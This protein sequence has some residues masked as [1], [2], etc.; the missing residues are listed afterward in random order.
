MIPAGLSPRA[1]RRWIADHLA[2]L[3][4][5]EAEIDARLLVR[6]ASGIDPALPGSAAEA[7]LGGDETTRL[8]DL[9]ARRS[10]HEPM[11]RIAGLREFRGLDFL[12][13]EACLVP[14]PDTET[15]VDVAL[16]LL[17][18][19]RPARILDLGT[20][21]G[22][23]VLAILSE[24]PGDHGVGIDAA[25]RAIEAARANARAL[26]LASRSVFHVGDWATGLAGPF[27]LVVSNPPYIPSPVCDTLAPEVRDHDPRLALDGGGDGLDAYR[28]ILEQ[29]GP[30]LAEGGHVLLELGIGQA[31]DVA[32]MART[33]GLAVCGLR[34]DLN[35]IPRALTLIRG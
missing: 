10:A 3:G 34:S 28:T 33:N 21:P 22:T 1:A 12:L 26:G 23:L 31:G 29:A 20:G 2:G 15:L 32:R 6:M 30:L 14:R 35:G 7:P 19:E 13:N 5:D 8:G 17:P 4:S 9:V 27:D 11:A 25:E 18:A 16:D 24:R